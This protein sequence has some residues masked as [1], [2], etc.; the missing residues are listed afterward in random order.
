MGTVKENKP[1]ITPFRNA[2]VYIF[3]T[4]YKHNVKKRNNYL[5]IKQ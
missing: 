3:S 4:K 5:E 2:N 1:Q